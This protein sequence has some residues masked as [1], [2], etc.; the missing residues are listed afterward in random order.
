MRAFAVSMV[1]LAALVGSACAGLAARADGLTTIAASY[2]RVVEPI[3]LVGIGAAQ[4]AGDIDAAK[5]AQLRQAVTVLGRILN[6][7]EVGATGATAAW[8]LLLPFAEAGI[9]SRVAN[10]DIGPGVGASLKE[11]LRLFGARLLQVATPGTVGAAAIPIGE[12]G[13]PVFTAGQQVAI[14]EALR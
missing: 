4:D 13:G 14:Q 8:N 5:A 11:V 12:R 2:S 6:S 9:D 7:G 3:V 1:L 10:G